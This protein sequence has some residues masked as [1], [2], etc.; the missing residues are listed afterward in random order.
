M[1]QH[2]DREDQ[3]EHLRDGEGVPDGIQPDLVRQNVRYRQQH[4][5]LTRDGHDHAEDAVA[6]RLKDGGADDG[7]AC[8]HKAEADGPKGGDAN[9]EHLLGR[10]EHQKQLTGDELDDHRPGKHDRDGV[11]RAQTHGL[12]DAVRA[13]RAVVE[14]DDRHHAVVQTENRHENEA[15]ELEIDAEDGG[16]RFADLTEGEENFVDAVGHER[17]DGAH[18]GGGNANVENAA[19]ELS[20]HA[21]AA[22]REAQLR[23][24]AHI[25]HNADRSADELPEDGRDGGASYAHCRDAERGNAENED[26]VK[27]DVGDRTG[28]LRDHGERGA[29]RRL[30]Q[31][32]KDELC[33]EPG[34]ENAADGKIIL[35]ERD[36]LLVCGL[37]AEEDVH[38]KEACQNKDDAAERLD[39]NAL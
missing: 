26:G 3:A 27:D 5:K 8:E 17:A 22:Q 4:G 25:Q 12:K 23:V 31:T 33:E 6:E 28:A 38:R 21:E 29:S 32:L 2:E 30:K 35:A 15:L 10:V 24:P 34:G 37:P 11:D 20:V 36:D 39:E 19:A 9:A 14:G 13:A 16:C 18:D 1:A 7:K